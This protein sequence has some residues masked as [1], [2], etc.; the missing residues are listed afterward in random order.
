M[1]R[2]V[3]IRER[4]VN[5]CI[6]LTGIIA[7]LII[8]IITPRLQ[9][10]YEQKDEFLQ[11]EKLELW[12]EEE[13]RLLID[14]RALFNY[15]GISIYDE[16]K[17]KLLISMLPE[18]NRIETLTIG[19][20]VGQ[21]G[22]LIKYKDMPSHGISSKNTMEQIV[23]INSTIL[24]S[25]CNDL[26]GVITKIDKGE[27]IEERVVYKGDLDRYFEADIRL[28]WLLE[29][30]EKYSGHFLNKEAIFKYTGQKYTYSASL[31]KEV[32]CF[33]KLNFVETQRLQ[34]N[35]IPYMD[36][37]MGQALVN[38][39]GYK[40]FV[41][42]LKYDNDYMNY[43]SAYRLLE[44]YNEIDL[45][46]VLVELAICKNRTTSE[47][48]KLACAYVMG[49]LGDSSTG[50]TVWIT[51]F[52]E[53]TY[54]GGKKVYMIKEQEI[55]EWGKWQ[56]PTAVRKCTISPNE[57]MVWCYGES[58]NQSYAYV[59][60]VE[61][62]ES[63]NLGKEIVLREDGEEAPELTSMAK[64]QLQEKGLIVAAELENDMEIQE[65]W[66]KEIFLKIQLTS[67]KIKQSQD[68]FYNPVNRRLTLVTNEGEELSL[69]QLVYEL[70]DIL[71]WGEDT[72]MAQEALEIEGV[73]LYLN[74]AYV[75]VYEYGSMAER[76]KHSQS[77]RAEIGEDHINKKVYLFEKGRVL[78]R[79]EGT[80]DQVINELTQALNL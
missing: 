65:E 15:K 2:V 53:N 76:E 10:R 5:L 62:K 45:E 24:M 30:F 37:D 64:E 17:L 46:E 3:G 8:T 77:L 49:V 74:E 29:D 59:L 20:E 19:N 54:G 32:D 75:T 7:I 40:L 28:S 23:L 57:E 71:V 79:Y 9:L 68:L 66:F 11:E 48:V 73:R 72:N 63:Y 44:F 39:Y 67:N 52:R 12:Q 55:K 61:N 33:F 21:F 34:E 43:Y 50:K 31:G 35:E 18:G 36:E 56:Q 16:E 42:G 6:I 69:A 1:K 41:E 70:S 25:L 4:V 27:G 80:E 14:S 26:N 22:I 51:R 78:I 47:S 58:L 13:N 60:P 38:K